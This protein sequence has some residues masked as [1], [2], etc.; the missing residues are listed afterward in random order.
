MSHS[1][2]QLRCIICGRIYAPAQVSYLCPHHGQEGILDVVYDYEA[3]RQQISR[4]RLQVNPDHSI[5]RYRA[6]LPISPEAPVPPL[7]VGWTPLYPAPRL[8]EGL[9]LSHLWVKDD[10]RNPTASFKD[11][12]SAVAVVKAQEAGS[13]IVTTASTGNAAAAWLKL[14]GVRWVSI[15]PSRMETAARQQVKNS[16]CFC[17]GVIVSIPISMRILLLS[18]NAEPDR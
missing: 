2:F 18:L 12:A 8:A 14:G 13:E 5:W 10:G 3:L 4:E 11:R 9:G 16:C 6:L 7:Q 1:H 15:H 17:M